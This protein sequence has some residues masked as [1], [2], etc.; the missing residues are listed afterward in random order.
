[1]KALLASLATGTIL[2]TSCGVNQALVINTN[3]N[4]TQVQLT[5]ANFRTVGKA[6]GTDSVAYVLCFGGM[7][8]KH[9][10]HDAYADMLRQAELGSGARAVVNVLTEEHLGGFPPFFYK[11]TLTVS[12]DVIE[13]TK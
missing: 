7:K 13:F 8:K 6:M 1:M 9:M 11:R 2:L 4:T 3:Q 12:G 5:Q 10:Y